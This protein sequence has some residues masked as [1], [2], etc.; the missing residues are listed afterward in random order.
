MMRIYVY[1]EMPQGKL[2][3]LDLGC[4]E[5]AVGIAGTKGRVMAFVRGGPKQAGPYAKELFSYGVDTLLWLRIP[6]WGDLE[7][8]EQGIFRMAQYL[9]KD[10][11]AGAVIF[12]ASPLGN[13]LASHLGIRLHTDSV[14]DCVAISRESETGILIFDRPSGQG[15]EIIRY[16]F[17]QGRLPVGTLKQ[18]GRQKEVIGHKNKEKRQCQIIFL[19]TDG[20]PKRVRLIS[21]KKDSG[22]RNDIARQACLVAGGQGIKSREDFQ[23]LERLA[24]KLGGALCVSRPV[25]DKGWYPKDIQVGLSGKQVAPKLYIAVGISGAFQHTVGMAE[26]GYVVAINQDRNASIFDVAD[27]GIVGAYRKVLPL[28]LEKW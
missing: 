20:Y 2:S 19:D 26:A 3:M 13:Q 14:L 4:L 1:L 7:V 11:G 5:T 16:G 10:P 15:R 23:L 21:R 9:T 8:L 22:E 12:P 27:F 17:L 18:N 6:E 28:L 24:E 25:V